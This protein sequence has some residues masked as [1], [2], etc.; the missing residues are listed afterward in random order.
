VL[1]LLPQGDTAC[2]EVVTQRGGAGTA[3]VG[4]RQ[5]RRWWPNANTTAAAVPWRIDRGTAARGADV[6]EAGRTGT[7]EDSPLERWV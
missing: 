3:M 4:T 2:R 5:D 1:V 7:V 6:V